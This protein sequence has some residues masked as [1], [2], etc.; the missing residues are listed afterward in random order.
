MSRNALYDYEMVSVGLIR[1]T[2]RRD[3]R[4]QLYDK[5]LLQT[6]IDKTGQLFTGDPSNAE[7]Y[8]EFKKKFMDGMRFINGETL[9]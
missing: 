7:E 6:Y 8:E 1:I 5:T 4:S 3:G 2:D 9:T